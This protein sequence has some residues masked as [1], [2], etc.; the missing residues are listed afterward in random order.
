V[1][2]PDDRIPAI[3]GRV[4]LVELVT[5]FAGPAVSV[6]GGCA[7][8]RCPNPDHL[9]A[10]P[11]FTVKGDR[12]RC[13]SQCG[14]SGRAIDFM[15]FVGACSTLPEAIDQLATRVGLSRSE[16]A[17]P[18]RS[19]KTKVAPDVAQAALADY[20]AKRCWPSDL[21]EDLGLTVVRDRL[22]FLRVRHPF[23]LDGRSVCWQARAIDDGMTPRWRSSPGPIR[24]P[25]EADRLGQADEAGV[26]VITEG[27]SDA[28][29]V[30]AGAPNIPVVGIPGSTGFKLSWAEAFTDLSVFVLG[31]NDPAGDKFRAKVADALGATASRIIQIPVPAPY[32]DVSDWLISV[33]D[34]QVFGREFVDSCE[35]AIGGIGGR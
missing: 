31:D 18:G 27:L 24:C 16:S 22:G 30:L 5:D 29:S 34:A 2:G 17:P 32:N 35:A 25:Y 14:Q 12:W 10:H 8:F 33:G 7:K 4:D 21:A 1:T 11:S 15:L 26:V 9:D 3:M 28:V 23:R 13:W 6:A 19:G 20:L